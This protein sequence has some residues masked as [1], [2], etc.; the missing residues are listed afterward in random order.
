MD[1]YEKD[2]DPPKTWL[3]ETGGSEWNTYC[4]SCGAGKRHEGK[5][6]HP[7]GGWIRWLETSGTERYP[8]PQTCSDLGRT[9]GLCS[10]CTSDSLARGGCADTRPRA[11]GRGTEEGA[12]GAAGWKARPG[13]GDAVILLT[14]ARL[15]EAA[16]ATWREIDLRAGAWTIPPERQK[17]T[18]RR[19]RN[20]SRRKPL[21]VPLSN[22]AM[23]LL[24]WLKP[25]DAGWSQAQDA[26]V[27]PRQAR[28]P[29]GE[30]G[31]GATRAIFKASGTSGWHRHDLRRTGSTR[32][33]EAGIPPHVIEAALN[34][35]TIHS[36]LAGRYNHSR[37]REDVKEALQALAVRYDRLITRYRYQPDEIGEPEWAGVCG[38]G[39]NR[40]DAST[41]A[42]QRRSATPW[43]MGFQLYTGDRVRQNEPTGKAPK[44][45]PTEED[46]RQEVRDT[47]SNYGGRAL[48]S[49]V[50][51]ART[52]TGSMAEFI[53]HERPT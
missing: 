27:F 42:D 6:H 13:E 37:Y 50:A 38:S 25:K 35:G 5:R 8:C 20:P 7:G 17:D 40:H 34:H 30:L 45:D 32:M 16:G 43:P 36:E 29:T 53:H 22:P 41:Q 1:R 28:R 14:L 19:K 15:E 21:I 18:K 51:K 10:R 24:Q 12:A 9:P 52:R 31:P 3:A 47:G 49:A 44:N 11:D 48:T 26:L 4:A 39:A 23:T 46:E 2:G 33:G